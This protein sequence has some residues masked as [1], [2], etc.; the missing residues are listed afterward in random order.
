MKATAFCPG[1]ITG[2]FSPKRHRD[3]LKSGSLGAGICIDQGA[4]TTLS[5]TEGNRSIK[6]A[7]DGNAAPVTE[8]AL[9][10]LLGDRELQIRSETVLQLPCGAGFGTS[11]AG[12]ISA[13]AALCSI[14]S[15]SREEAVRAA[16]IAEIKHNTGLGDV[17]A[18]SRCGVTYRLKEG[19]KPYGRVERLDCTPTITAC[20]FKNPL[21]TADILTDKEKNKIISKAGE[22]CIAEM[23]RSPSLDNLFALSRR[24][25]DESMLASEEVTEA[26]R[27]L[28]DT[29]A[30][31]IM[32]G[33]SVFALGS[34]AE[35]ILSAFGKT[36]VLHTDTTGPRILTRTE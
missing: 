1:H 16:H 10:L 26:L 29:Q 35:D 23:R 28:G 14:L 8:T 6:A 12:T 4:V 19:V 17:A 7:V 24:F 3:P 30:S 15:L 9:D 18:I 21:S 34:G 2:F 5:A 27:A 33:N 22:K 13:A 32:L 31:M 11:A 20:V 36:F 25:T